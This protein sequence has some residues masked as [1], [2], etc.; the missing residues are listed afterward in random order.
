MYCLNT[1]FVPVN[2]QYDV[3]IN[4]TKVDDL[5]VDGT[6]EL[7]FVNQKMTKLPHTGS[8]QTLMMTLLGVT[9]MYIAIK[10]RIKE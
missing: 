7:E 1:D 4:H 2:G 8:N 9:I 10:R 6:I 3:Y 5:Y